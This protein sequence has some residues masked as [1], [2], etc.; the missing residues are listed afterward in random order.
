M[1]TKVEREIFMKIRKRI[2]SA[3]T[4]LSLC[5]S[6]M[7]VI[8][9]PEDVL[10]GV[11]VS[12]GEVTALT[13]IKD[14]S[15]ELLDNLCRQDYDTYSNIVNSYMFTKDDGTICIVNYSYQRLIMEQFDTDY[16][17]INSWTIPVELPIFG[18]FYAGND[19]YYV[20]SGQKKPLENDS[21]E[22]MRVVKY[23]KNLERIGMANIYGAN[24]VAPFSASGLRMDEKDGRLYIHTAHTMYLTPDGLN[25]QANIDINGSSYKV[26]SIAK[27]AL[28]NKTKLSKLIIGSNIKSI[29]KNT[30]K[31]CKNL[32]NIVI[33]S[34]KL[35]TKKTVS[36][37]F[38]DINSKATVKVPKSKVKKYGKLLKAKGAGKNIKV[39]K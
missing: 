36:G 22:V 33:K 1:F 9:V 3:V 29:G 37:A 5:L 18:G 4:A 25:H 21:V 34:K 39:K 31:G 30:F 38:K 6:L 28:K 11:K 23:N 8:N 19:G 17:F 27:N 7:P 15:P 12:A 16:N 2:L 26:A 14:G 35:T 20:V 10:G 32:K 13:P 24:T